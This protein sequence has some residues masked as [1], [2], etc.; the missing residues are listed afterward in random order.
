VT[1]KELHSGL[2]AQVTADLQHALRAPA[3][4]VRVGAGARRTAGGGQPH[5]AVQPASVHAASE[6]AAA[7][8]ARVT[9]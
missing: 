6:T 3:Q 9:C 4:R 5:H 2:P 7:S 1:H 8:T